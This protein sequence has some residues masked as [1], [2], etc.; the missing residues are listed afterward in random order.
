MGPC[1]G[2]L[3]ILKLKPKDAFQNLK[4]SLFF[5]QSDDSEDY[6]KSFECVGECALVIE[7]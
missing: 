1:A 5:N 7:K 2:I 4:K 6:K 3:S